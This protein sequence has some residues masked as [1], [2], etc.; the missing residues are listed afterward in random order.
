MASKHTLPTYTYGVEIE[1]FSEKVHPA[2]IAWTLRN[3]GFK[4][5][6]LVTEDIDRNNGYEDDY[7]DTDEYN[8]DEA[9]SSS[10]NPIDSGYDTETWTL[11][12]DGSIEGTN[13][14]EIKSP[15]LRG[16]KGLKEIQRL[17]FHLNKLGVK[18]NQ[19]CGLH[20]HIGITNADKKF[21]SNEIASILR[22]YLAHQDQIDKFLARS[23]R[24]THNQFCAPIDKLVESV[25]SAIDPMIGPEA[26][27]PNWLAMS[28]SQKDY[29]LRNGSGHFY[30]SSDCRYHEKPQPS[31]DG[32]QSL[33]VLGEHYHRVSVT[34]L[35]K[36]GTI[37]FRQHH[38][39]V[40]GVKITNWIR[41]L[42]NHVEMARNL[43][44]K[45]KHKGH[46]DHPFRGLPT[47]VRKHFI[48]QAKRLE[49]PRI[50]RSR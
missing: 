47:R 2:V 4:V 41:F 17:T 40:N 1:C 50:A 39:T 38:G 28:R 36:Y 3:A 14:V 16:L 7:E 33:A 13:P 24:G 29:W 27:P 31:G 21:A 44:E 12:H 46:T 26:P 32:I 37:E 5:N 25:E 18:V 11:G 43:T 34:P 8:D 45:K 10:V 19:S 42:L 23:R 49:T 20:V 22:R 15:I 30:W 6:D 9:H 48:E 35:K